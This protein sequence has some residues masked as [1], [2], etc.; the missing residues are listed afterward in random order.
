MNY[1]RE[2]IVMGTFPIKC[3]EIFFYQYLPIKMAHNSIVEIPDRLKIFDHLICNCIYEEGYAW[4]FDKYVYITAKHLFV[5]PQYWGNRPG[6][7]TDGFMTDDINFIWSDC[8]PTIFNT[9]N[10]NITPDHKQSLIEF[11]T[12]AIPENEKTYPDNTLLKLDQYVVHKVA[13]V[14]EQRFRT[15]VKISISR[16]KYNLKGNTHNYLFDYKWE[17][18]ERGKD[19]NDTTK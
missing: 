15:F 3:D 8:N 9:S 11:E 14:T 16:E 6:Y 5:T 19:R 12:Q 1:G 13:P 18:V 17:M 4:L 2:P 10:F 7:H